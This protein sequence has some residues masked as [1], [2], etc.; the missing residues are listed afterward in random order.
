MKVDVEHF[1]LAVARVKEITDRLSAVVVEMDAIARLLQE[2][3]HGAEGGP[4][5]A[6]ES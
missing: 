4:T 3:R 6:G 5:D 2:S 1:E